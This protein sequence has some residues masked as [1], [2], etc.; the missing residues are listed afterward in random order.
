[1]ILRSDFLLKTIPYFVD[2]LRRDEAHLLGFLQ[3][4]QCFYQPD[5][6]QYALYSEKRAPNE[7]DFF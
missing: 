2:A 3:T 4:P 6:F 7:Q 1:M 5:V